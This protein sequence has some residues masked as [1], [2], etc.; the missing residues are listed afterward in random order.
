LDLSC[1]AVVLSGLRPYSYSGLQTIHSLPR[2]FRFFPFALAALLAV[3]VAGCGLLGDDDNGNGTGNTGPVNQPSL[4][5]VQVIEAVFSSRITE[6]QRAMGLI[7][8]VF[9]HG[10]DQMHAVLI[11]GNV[12]AGTEIVGRWYQL[13]VDNAP[14]DGQEITQSHITLEE[15][16]I[17]QGT[18]RL[19]LHLNAA[20]RFL[21]PGAWLLRVYEGRNLIRT[22]SFYIL[23]DPNGQQPGVPTPAP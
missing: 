8:N 5:N 16:Q 11:L 18:A 15:G 6:D 7:G 1:A 14:P 22:L 23:R 4:S 2:F 9:P 12:E 17:A 10:L 13:D 21:P 3:L 19:A 20:G